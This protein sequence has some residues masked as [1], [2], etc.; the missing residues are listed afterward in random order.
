MTLS[1]RITLAFVAAAKTAAELDGLVA[2]DQST[3]LAAQRLPGAVIY[4]ESEDDPIVTNDRAQS[5]LGIAVKILGKG[6]DGRAAIDSAR[7]Q[8]HRAIWTDAALRALAISLHRA[9]AEWA[10]EQADET[11]FTV[12]QHYRVTFRTLAADIEVQG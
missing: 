4:A 6:P 3:V 10:D 2:R 5:S 1:E 8:V 11:I 12:T 9:A 7:A